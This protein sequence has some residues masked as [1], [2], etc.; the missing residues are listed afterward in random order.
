M[1]QIEKHETNGNSQ[2]ARA[3]S[4]R[5]AV[6]ME[7]ECGASGAS[8]FHSRAHIYREFHPA[9]T[10]RAVNI[11]PLQV[12]CYIIAL[13]ISSC[14]RLRLALRLAATDEHGQA[15]KPFTSHHSPLIS[16][17]RVKVSVKVKATGRDSR[18]SPGTWAQ[19]PTSL[20]RRLATWWPAHCLAPA[21]RGRWLGGW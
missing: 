5:S 17:G 9:K 14:L 2:L 12:N 10:F 3:S 11:P 20:S 18:R 15:R 16:G 21:Q 4:P 8:T 7:G 1:K 19:W 13:N 6:S